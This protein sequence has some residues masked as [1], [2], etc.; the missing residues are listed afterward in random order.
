M[1]LAQVLANLRAMGYKLYTSVD[2]S[3]GGDNHDTESWVF[4]RVGNAWS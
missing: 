3:M 4:R 1:M 2:I